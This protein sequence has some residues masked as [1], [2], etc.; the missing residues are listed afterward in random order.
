MQQGYLNIPPEVTTVWADTGY[1][2]VQDKGEV[3][4]GRACT[5]TSPC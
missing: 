3:A 5:T 4:R 2:L 1:G